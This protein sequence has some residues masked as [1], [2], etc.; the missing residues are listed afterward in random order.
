MSKPL[1]I[2]L[3]IVLAGCVGLA[4]ELSGAKSAL[5]RSLKNE[6]VLYAANVAQNATISELRAAKKRDDALV[7]GTADKID[8]L[9]TRIQGLDRRTR[10]ALKNA[11]LT[12]DS[13]LPVAAADALCL[14]WNAASGHRIAYSAGDPPGGADA[15]AG[16]PQTPDCRRWR[17]LTVRDAVEWNGLLLDHAGREREDKAALRSWAE[18][19]G[20]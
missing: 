4:W 13:L 7:S 8:E 2:L 10:E 1:G 15:R 18:K 5:E 19:A 11:E 12:L 3:I 20:E 17:K 6:G 9:T 14:Q 16:D